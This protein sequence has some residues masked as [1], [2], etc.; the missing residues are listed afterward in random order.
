MALQPCL[1]PRDDT[2]VHLPHHP[3]PLISN[4]SGF[5]PISGL[6]L[7][8]NFITPP[9]LPVQ[10]LCCPFHLNVLSPESGMPEQMPASCA[11]VGTPIQQLPGRAMALFGDDYLGWSTSAFEAPFQPDSLHSAQ[12]WALPINN[13]GH[14]AMLSPIS[15]LDRQHWDNDTNLDTQYIRVTDGSIAPGNVARPGT[16]NHE[17]YPEELAL[18]PVDSVFH[19][20]QASLPLFIFY[21][22]QLLTEIQKQPGP[23]SLFSKGNRQLRR[24]RSRS[25]ESVCGQGVIARTVRI[26]GHGHSCG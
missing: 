10:F 7:S 14:L 23:D 8:T 21:C 6:F 18:P 17:I 19:A 11:S 9:Y 12:G 1:L 26:K 15:T 20:R 16:S 22:K 3:N 24:N 5:P 2:I 13:D 25:V 4:S